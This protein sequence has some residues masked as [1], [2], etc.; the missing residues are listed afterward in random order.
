[1]ADNAGDHGRWR[2]D[3]PKIAAEVPGAP[4]TVDEAAQYVLELIARMDQTS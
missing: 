3:Y 4:S 1:M 2:K